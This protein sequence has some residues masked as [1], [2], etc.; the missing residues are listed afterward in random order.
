[1]VQQT[2]LAPVQSLSAEQYFRPSCAGSH[3]VCELSS[4]VC[5]HA[6]PIAV[7]QLESALQNFGQLLASWQ[8]LR[9]FP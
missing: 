6:W 3:T 1:M 7:S 9:P 5:T 4:D 2:S 8:I